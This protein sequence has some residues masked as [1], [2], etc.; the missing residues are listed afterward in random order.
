MGR[1]ELI[2]IDH[3][4]HPTVAENVLWPLPERNP[5]Y[6]CLIGIHIMKICSADGEEICSANLDSETT[7]LTLV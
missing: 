1:I 2:I 6:T 7:F 4:P 5:G 3:T